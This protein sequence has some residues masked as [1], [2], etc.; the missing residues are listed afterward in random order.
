MRH[1]ATSAIP[2]LSNGCFFSIEE[3]IAFAPQIAVIAN[4]APFHIVT[5]QALA[6]VGVHLL[7]EKPLSASLDGITQLLETCHKQGTVLLTGYNLRFLP[8][9]QR[10]HTLL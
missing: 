1:R 3:A 9:L 7:V 10:F 2:E 8:S 6:E 4:P 5:A